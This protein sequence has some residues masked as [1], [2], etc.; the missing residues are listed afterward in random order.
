MNEIILVGGFP[1][2]IELCEL[3]G[4]KIV[5]IVDNVQ[6]GK[7]L[8]YSVLGKDK[9][10]AHL[11]HKFSDIPVIVAVDKPAIR[12]KLIALYR[13]VGFTFASIISP[14]AFVSPS[15]KL[16]EGVIVQSFCNISTNVIVGDFVKL[17]T[18]ANAMHDCVIEDYCTIAPNAVLLGNVYVGKASYI[19]AN[20]TVIQTNRI[21]KNVTVGAS[22]V[23]TKDIMDGLTVIGVPARS[24]MSG[25]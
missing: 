19:G 8:G 16:G 1:E 18:Y 22:A 12:Q 2:T 14:K 6:D 23:V 11:Y 17:N 15:A 21:G 13:Q 7:I 20:A 5:G 4:Y 9:D 24:R 3:C 10:A 25:G